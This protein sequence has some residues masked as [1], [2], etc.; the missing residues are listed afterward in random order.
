LK[1][2]WDNKISRK[3]SKRAFPWHPKRVKMGNI[4]EFPQVTEVWGGF[5]VV[6][7]FSPRQVCI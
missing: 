6:Q 1:I 3:K 7:D 5:N 2:I 4:F